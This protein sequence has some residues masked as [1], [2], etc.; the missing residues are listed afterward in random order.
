MVRKEYFSLSG[1]VQI[2]VTQREAGYD[3]LNTERLT[4]S[5][6]CRLWV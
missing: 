4:M 1:A 5:D 3:S 2:G 6:Y